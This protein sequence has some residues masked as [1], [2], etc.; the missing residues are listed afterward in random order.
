[1]P[2]TDRRRLLK[3]LAGI[4]VAGV[5]GCSMLSSS[6]SQ[7]QTRRAPSE[8]PPGPTRLPQGEEVPGGRLGE[9]VAM[10]GDTVL[11]GALKGRNRN[12]INTGSVHAYVRSGEQWSHQEAIVPVDG[13]VSGFFGKS[14]ALWQDTALVGAPR[15]NRGGTGPENGAAYVY[16]R[17]DGTWQKQTK[18]IPE[19]LDENSRFG[20][21]VALVDGTTVVTAPGDD[22]G[23]GSAY[24]FE[25]SDGAWN[26]AGVLGSDELEVRDA[27]GQDVAIAGEEVVVGAVGHETSGVRGRGAAFVFEQAGGEWN[28]SAALV[29]SSEDVFVDELGASVASSDGT[30]IVGSPR[31]RVDESADGT[32][33]VFVRSDD[34]WQEQTVLSADDGDSGDLFGT[35]VAIWKDVAV[36]GAHRDDEPGGETAGSAYH[37]ERVDGTWTQR[38]K[39]A[40]ETIRS[41]DSFG[42]S[43][44]VAGSATVVG[45]PRH[46]QPDPANG[47]AAFVYGL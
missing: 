35:A 23:I 38:A 19:Q 20:Y 21:S 15:D 36:V 9:S 44:A 7:G 39:L 16:E 11:V 45:A 22:D 5:A 12:D 8:V 13:V 10:D 28:Q 33:V 47:G 14:V 31:G 3:S 6:G 4:G 30:V 1:M 43:V 37:F 40:P 26:R 18:L 42:S 17:T 25:R 27:F 46:D 34:G 32:A 29:P 41:R 24:V 2:G